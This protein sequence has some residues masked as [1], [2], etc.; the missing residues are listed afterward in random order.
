ML[1]VTLI[2]RGLV[3]RPDL[4]SIEARIRQAEK[5]LGITTLHTCAGDHVGRGGAA[6]MPDLD[7]VGRSA[8]N[9][10]RVIAGYMRAMRQ[11]DTQNAMNMRLGYALAY[12]IPLMGM[13]M[14][15]KFNDVIMLGGWA[16]LLAVIPAL[17]AELQYRV[18]GPDLRAFGIFHAPFNIM[19]RGSNVM[20]ATLVANLERMM[21]SLSIKEYYNDN[22]ITETAR[23]MA[24]THTIVAVAGKEEK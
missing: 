11:I 18:H 7:Y 5:T 21:A 17:M 22:L 16:T 12:G 23:Q 19:P 13:D 2:R 14:L 8:T 24:I 9:D 15:L 6:I 20:P 1:R 10:A 4:P 3:T